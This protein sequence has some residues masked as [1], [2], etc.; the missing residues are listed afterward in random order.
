MATE[1]GQLVI[2]A[3]FSIREQPTQR[4]AQTRTCGEV[5][6][7]YGIHRVEAAMMTIDQINRDPNILPNIT[8]G[9]EIRDSCWYSAI[10]LEQSIE[11]IRDAMAASEEKAIGTNKEGGT[12]L[13]DEEDL[14][15]NMPASTSVAGDR[16]LGLFPSSP[17]TSMTHF[18]VTTPCPKAVK[19]AKNIVGVIGPASS[20]NCIQVQNLLQLFNIPQIGYSST[21]KDLSRKDYYKFFLRVVPS[22]HHQA[23]VITRLFLHFNWTYV[24]VLYTDGSYGN[25]LMETFKTNAQE[26]GICIANMEPIPANGEDYIFDQVIRNLLSNRNAK[27]VACFCEGSSARA[28]LQAKRRLNLTTEFLFVGR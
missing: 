13:Y 3:L 6:E 27:V 12:L 9:I 14:S 20:T 16:I 25:G 22:D 10:A 26:A 4:A 18:N 19:K 28:L 7:Q 1:H 5:R 15:L 17:F 24:Q 23:Q 2:G 8:L 11:F 21:T